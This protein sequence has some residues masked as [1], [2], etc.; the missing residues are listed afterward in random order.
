MKKMTQFDMIM[1]KAR[2]DEIEKISPLAIPDIMK[3]FRNTF[4][5]KVSATKL[6]EELYNLA[7]TQLP[8]TIILDSLFDRIDEIKEVD[9]YYKDEVA[10]INRLLNFV[11]LAD[12]MIKEENVFTVYRRKLYTVILTSF[13]KTFKKCHQ[14]SKC[15][16][17]LH[18]YI[19]AEE[20]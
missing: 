20:V 16:N 12:T 10:S 1:I 3:I 19:T 9:W 15:Y 7:D 14:P 8:Y 17:L 5:H 4:I 11:E 6:D 2:F 18:G 13:F